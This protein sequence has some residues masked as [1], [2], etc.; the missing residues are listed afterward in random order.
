[1]IEAQKLSQNRSQMMDVIY[2][3]SDHPLSDKAQ[4]VLPASLLI[5]KEAKGNITIVFNTSV[6]VYPDICDKHIIAPCHIQYSHGLVK[7]L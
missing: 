5:A 1:M 4:I 3:A 6:L 7:C 2:P